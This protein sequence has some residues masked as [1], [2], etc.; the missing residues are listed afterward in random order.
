M[1]ARIKEIGCK[2]CH[3]H[4]Y[5]IF[6]DEE[7]SYA[8]T[9]ECVNSCDT[10]KGTGFISYKNENN[11][12]ML[13]TCTN[14][15]RLRSN[16]K[17]YNLAKIPAKFSD[18]PEVNSYQ[19]VNPHQQEALKYV[20]NSFIQQYPHE[21]GYVLMGKAGVGKTHLAIGTISE[22]TMEKGISCL[23]KDFFLLLSELRQAYSEGISEKEILHP[24]LET[25]VLVIDEMGKGKSSEWELNILDQLISS[26][27]NSSKK[28]IVTT[29][30]LSKQHADKNHT[31]YELLEERVGERIFS[32][33]NEMCKF[34]YIDG[35]D[36]RIKTS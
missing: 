18:V 21:K 6:T 1:E 27:Y 29:N 12:D 5:L 17:K 19:P 23:F 15:G 8:K 28:T 30:F 3:H 20:K 10:C 7:F 13:A 35:E 16:I 26:R 25:E 24:L 22:L 32:R 11:Y 36:F 31:S 2:D 33:L 14:C 34:F 4:G 9:C